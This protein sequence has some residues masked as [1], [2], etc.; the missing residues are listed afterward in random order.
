M[1]VAQVQARQEHVGFGAAANLVHPATGYSIART[2][3]AAPK[4][5]DA[6]ADSLTHQ[7]DHGGSSADVAAEVWTS[8]WSPELRCVI[9]QKMSPVC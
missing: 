6:I 5:A 2:L 8:L 4:M 7:R 9:I 3:S 1:G